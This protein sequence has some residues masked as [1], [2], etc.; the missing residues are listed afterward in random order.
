MGEAWLSV[1]PSLVEEYLKICL[2]IVSESCHFTAVCFQFPS[3]AVCH[4][5]AQTIFRV[6]GFK[7]TPIVCGF[8]FSTINMPLCMVILKQVFE[9]EMK[10]IK[11]PFP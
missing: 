1:L 5:P 7:S 4:T 3:D 2:N 6:H 11:P 9:F 8:L 10:Q